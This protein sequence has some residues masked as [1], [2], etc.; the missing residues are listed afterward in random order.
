LTGINIEHQKQVVEA[1]QYFIQFVAGPLELSC[2][3]KGVSRSSSVGFESP[4]LDYR[5]WQVQDRDEINPAAGH[6][7]RRADLLGEIVAVGYIGD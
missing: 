5:L 1:M 2:V 6:G 4:L 3:S 7:R